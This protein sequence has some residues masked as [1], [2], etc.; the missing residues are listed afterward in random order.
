LH[1]RPIQKRRR[2]DDTEARSAIGPAPALPIALNLA[3]V[4]LP[5]GIR[6]HRLKTLQRELN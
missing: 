5:A 1:Q 3:G 6:K 4:G 2:F